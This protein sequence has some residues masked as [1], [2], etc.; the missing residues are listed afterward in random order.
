ML[1]SWKSDQICVTTADWSP[2]IHF[3][4]EDMNLYNT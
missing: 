3:Y 1:A 2:Y 4:E